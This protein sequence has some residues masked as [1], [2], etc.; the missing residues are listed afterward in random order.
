MIK[1]VNSMNIL[2]RFFL[3]KLSSNA[4]TNRYAEIEFDIA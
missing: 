2:V 1:F 3:K 4:R